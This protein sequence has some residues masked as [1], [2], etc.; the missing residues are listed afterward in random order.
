[1]SRPLRAVI[2]HAAL[3]NNLHRVRAA[4]PGSAVMAVVKADA[5]GHGAVP[6][7]RTLLAAGADSLGVIGVDEALR[8][9]SAGIQATITLLQGFYHPSE[10]T[11]I[12]AQQLAIVLH[13]PQQIDPLTRLPGIAQSP[14][15]RAWVKVDTG[16]HRLGFPPSQLAATLERLDAIPAIRPHPGLFSHLASGDVIG[17]ADTSTQIARFQALV[18]RF[19]GM[20]TSLANSA[21]VLAWPGSHAEQASAGAGDSVRPG[22][23]LYGSSPFAQGPSASELGLQA[24]MR[25]ESELIA[26]QSLRGGDRVGYGGCWECP[27]DMPVGLVAA[28]YGDGYPRHA[29]S[30]T[31]VRVG[32]VRVPLIGRVSM[33]SLCVDLRGCARPQVGDPVVLWGESP[34][35][36]EVATAAG[37]I[38]YEPLCQVTARV[39]R[40]HVNQPDATY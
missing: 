22:I 34:G 37:T 3:I 16:M 12:G 10:L 30:G 23:M 31:P 20:P 40:E 14:P 28:G 24:V 36:D 29:P 27:E 7:A 6:V 13:S 25:L 21:G 8:L 4:A 15:I 38:A 17:S 26:V 33:D 11:E 19:P 35:I 2:D 18:Q 5:Y 9:R 39:P 1:M 32:G